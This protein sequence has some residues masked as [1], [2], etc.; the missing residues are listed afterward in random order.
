M[1]KGIHKKTSSAVSV[2]NKKRKIEFK[3]KAKNAFEPIA[4]IGMSALFPKAED[5]TQFWDNILQK[6]NCITDVPLEYWDPSDYF[7]SD[8]KVPGK[9]YCKQAG[10]VPEIEFDP[11][12]FGI[13]PVNLESICLPQLFALVLAKRALLDAGLLGATP[14]S[15]NKDKTG[16][17]LG[18][19][20]GNT[21]FP[22]AGLSDVT[23]IIEVIRQSNLSK[24]SVDLINEKINALYVDWQENS[25]PGFLGNVVSGRV[26]NH[27]DFGGTNCTVDAACASSLSAVKVAIDELHSGSCDVMLTGGVNIDNSIFSFMCFSKTPALSRK[28]QSRPYDAQ[29]DGMMLGDGVGMLVLKRLADAERDGDRIYALIT[30]IGASSDGRA[31]SIYAPRSE[32][33]IKALK[34]AY[35]NAGISPASIG[36]VEGHG[37]GTEVGDACELRSLN[38]VFRSNGSIPKHSIALGSVKSQI[39][40]TRTAAGIAGVLKAVLAL[41]QKVL[42]PTINVSQPNPALAKE[43]SPLYL[44][45]ERRPWIREGNNQGPRRAAVSAFGFGGTNYHLVLEEYEAEHRSD[46]RLHSVPEIITMHAENKD[47][48]LAD[49]KSLLV[50]LQEKQRHQNYSLFLQQSV[51]NAIPIHHARVGF[52]TDSL[53]KTVENL[54]KTVRKLQGS[55]EDEW[56]HP[57]GIYFRSRGLKLDGKV[58]AMFPG[59]GSQYVGM[60]NA[61]TCNYPELRIAFQD[62]NILR[63]RRGMAPVS[64]LVYPVPALSGLDYRKQVEELKK[65]EH[66]QSAIA[67][68]SAG[69]Y[70]LLQGYGFKPDFTLGH[71]FGELTALWAAGVMDRTNYFELAIERGKAMAL[72]LQD[73]R[74]SGAMLSVALGRDALD[75]ILGEFSEV[76]IANEN[77]K[78]QTV[79]AGSSDDIQRLHNHFTQQG[80]R[81]TILPVSAAFHTQFVQHARTPFAKTLASKKL[82]VG[83]TPTYSTVTCSPYPRN[84][85]AIRKLLSDQIVKP[86]LFRQTVEEIHK[87]G[88][89][90]FVEI[91]PRSI[92][93]GLVDNILNDKPHLC[94]AVNPFTEKDDEVQFRQ[95][96][97]QFLVAGLP[98][99]VQDKYGKIVKEEQPKP[100]KG[101]SIRLGGNVYYSDKTRK[102][103]N[104]AMEE[105]YQVALEPNSHCKKTSNDPKTYTRD[106]SAL[107]EEELIVKEK[108]LNDEIGNQVRKNDQEANAMRVATETP[109][110]FFDSRDTKA[111]SNQSNQAIESQSGLQP[112][113]NSLTSESKE[114]IESSNHGA[115]SKGHHIGNSH[116]GH[117]VQSILSNQNLSSQVHN[118][119]L[120][121]Q[122]Q[123][124]ELMGRVSKLQG[125]LFEKHH[126][127]PQIQQLLGAQTTLLA[128]VQQN[129]QAFM[130]THDSYLHSQLGFLTTIVDPASNSVPLNFENR[131]ASGNI[132]HQPTTVETE[133]LH[134]AATPNPTQDMASVSM[135]NSSS[136]A[137]KMATSTPVDDSQDHPSSEIPQHNFEQ[138][139]QSASDYWNQIG[140]KIKEIFQAKTG[141]PADTLTEDADL[142]A[143]LGVDLVKLLDIGTC[144][145]ED[146][147]GMPELNTEVITQMTTFK[148]VMDY[149]RSHLGSNGKPE[150]MIPDERPTATVS[151][152]QINFEVNRFETR[153]LEI[154]S[155]KTGYPIDMLELDMA[156]EADLGIDSIKTME[157]F[158]ALFEEFP[159]IEAMDTEALYSMSTLADLVSYMEQ[160]FAPA[161]DENPDPEEPAKLLKPDKATPRPESSNRPVQKK[162]STSGQVIISNDQQ[163][164]IKGD[165]PTITSMG[166]KTSSLPPIQ[167]TSMDDITPETRRNKSESASMDNSIQRF[168]VV[169]KKL[170]TPDQIIE[171]FDPSHV[172]IVTSNGSTLGDKIAHKLISQG[173]KVVHVSW[174]NLADSDDSRSNKGEKFQKL[175]LGALTEDNIAET[176]KNIENEHRTIGGFIHIHPPP[177]LTDDIKNVFLETDYQTLKAVFLFA[178]LLKQNLN[179]EEASGKR[180]CFVTVTQTDG[181]LGV[182]PTAPHAMLGSGLNGLTKSLNREW[183]NVFCRAIDI[184][185]NLPASKAAELVFQELIDPFSSI[186]EVGYNENNERSTLSLEKT[187]LETGHGL[188]EAFPESSVILVTGGARG[189]TARCVIDLAAKQACK[190]III[191]RTSIDEPEP[192]W[193]R[194]CFDG[195]ELQNQAIIQLKEKG[196]KP[197]PVAIKKAIAPILSRREAIETISEI[198]KS[199]AEVIYISADISILKKVQQELKKVQNKTGP[200]T[201]LIHGAGSLADKKIEN[202]NVKDFQSVLDSKVKGLENVMNCL[203]PA[204]LRCLVLFSSVVGFYGNAG[205]T[206]YA[207]ANEVL[208]KY[209]YH[210][211]TLFPNT[212][213][214]AINWGPWDTG[215]V[216]PELKQA[217]QKNNIEV[218]PTEK[219]V[220][221]FTNEVLASRNG[222]VQILIG[223]DHFP[224]PHSGANGKCLTFQRQIRVGR[225]RFLYDHVIHEK[226]VLPATFA[227]QWMIQ[228]CEESSGGYHFSKVT[229]FRVLKGIIFDDLTP[230]SECDLVLTLTRCDDNTSAASDNDME[231]KVEI[232]SGFPDTKLSHYSAVIQ[233]RKDTKVHR[234]YQNFNLNEDQKISETGSQLYEKG[235]AFH[236]KSLRGIQ[237]VLNISDHQLTASCCLK[238][239]KEVQ[240][241]F[242]V[243]RF[244]PFTQDVMLQTILVWSQH[245][246]NAFCLPSAVESIRTYR[247]L[248]FNIPFYIT[249]EIQSKKALSIKAN[250]ISH[251]AEGEIYSRWTGVTCTYA[252]PS[253]DSIPSRKSS[254]LRTGQ[255]V[256]A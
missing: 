119:F 237:R 186:A 87:Q 51:K 60:M 153:L 219:G 151:S 196:E 48:L 183:T 198:E 32:G 125:D 95:A 131:L 248:P 34:R 129:Q 50:R 4:I 188:G 117:A 54:S 137:E 93:T 225:N 147:T 12:E 11:V 96:L 224:Y 210:F 1:R 68:V 84:S 200:I 52:V 7:D 203:N 193:A 216:R 55:S 250:I 171:P 124:L 109:S 255:V 78:N 209:A 245:Q 207:L 128:H 161:N 3:Q 181:H 115:P 256:I 206:D 169:S 88:G 114:G 45:T 58:V 251:N 43:E 185:R 220:G 80:Q 27:F 222:E 241:Q 163:R 98:I 31:K 228:G 182:G 24:E 2:S 236:G 247:F 127:T 28:S 69:A 26:T 38:Q 22:L 126:A 13:P 53:S 233:L 145:K 106:H 72:K 59:Q 235:L 231:Y 64:D 8:P 177:S 21:A 249:L 118:Q 221:F 75:A 214:A 215:M 17:V 176:V 10:I 62:V 49:C 141:F 242:P 36:L 135:D 121:N 61:L 142:E 105:G 73:M 244:N 33:Q 30:G 155:E 240:G 204:E 29:S 192:D 254:N 90:L 239:D 81:T 143:D 159:E 20:L 76:S 42:P 91:G 138:A 253:G 226:A 25:F 102:C 157:I 218:I 165:T 139:D 47:A 164:G 92:L 234:I 77:S 146:I 229:D 6:K 104:Q 172:W 70:H 85:S 130:A 86:V 208:N 101:M 113:G 103:R 18:A 15:F 123:Y 187:S 37:T 56:K 110:S 65:T 66:A 178:K 194:H 246:F 111:K 154:I 97:V 89:Y 166:Y 230:G 116:P 217:Y 144:I 120:R 5:L 14:K 67:A 9:T 133:Q 40:H 99:D 174:Q 23:K 175:Q 63:Q 74:D 252:K 107:R 150:K 191:G 180:K 158:A 112:R 136:L 199:G 167:V 148:D 132:M 168:R 16:V 19:L 149:F 197:T 243:I 46:Y 173:L 94:I 227:L 79:L 223:G 39:G 160:N 205:Q 213:V 82:S 179:R 108:E 162:E 190:F 134:P 232:S 156:F 195:A 238:E 100:R 152:H 170:P 189:I 201:G 212:K 35:E 71:S 140:G 41:N 83:I 211:K 202:K 44:N 57:S 184:S 122:C